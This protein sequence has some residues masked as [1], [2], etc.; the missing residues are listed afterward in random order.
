MIAK[1][2][3]SDD[4]TIEHQQAWSDNAFAIHSIQNYLNTEYLILWTYEHLKI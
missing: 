1:L 4:Q 3:K 2:N